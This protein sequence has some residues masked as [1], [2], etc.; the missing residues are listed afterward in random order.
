MP[1][2]L[3]RQLNDFEEYDE[4]DDELEPEDFDPDGAIAMWN[5]R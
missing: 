5:E 2:T 4:D 3:T 1:T